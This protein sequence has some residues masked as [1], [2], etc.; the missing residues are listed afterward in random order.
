MNRAASPSKSQV[1]KAGATIRKRFAVPYVHDPDWAVP[2]D[3]SA[4]FGVLIDYRSAHQVPLGKS[5]M[6]LRS[7][8]TTEGCQVE[9][10]Q[11]LKRIPTIVDKL[12]REPTIRLSTMQDIGGC[13]AVL[14]SI[15]EIRRVERRLKKN[16]PPVRVS[17]YIT[18]PRDS[19]YRGVHVTVDYDNRMIEVQ[20]RTRVMHEWAITVERLSGRLGEDLKGG[21][22]PQQVRDLLEAISEAMAIEEA[23]NVVG[24]VLSERVRELRELANPYLRGGS[25]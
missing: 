2:A 18:A 10:T 5:N 12:R 15:D 6:G 21:S 14:A 23:G 3:L 13:R 19:G 11:R 20:L 16:R 4:A 1:D 25:R 8:V 9:V 24:Q 7:M 22:G 17:D